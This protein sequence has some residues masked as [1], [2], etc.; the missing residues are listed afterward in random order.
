MRGQ[1]CLAGP[2]FWKP[3]NAQRPDDQSE[4]GRN[5]VVK[6]DAESAAPPKTF[7]RLIG[8]ARRAKFD[9]VKKPKQTKRQQLRRKSSRH[10][11]PKD[12]PKSDHLIPH[13]MARI[14]HLHVDG[15]G[16][17]RPTANGEAAKDKPKPMGIRQE[18]IER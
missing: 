9:G 15:A 1:S 2:K 3:L 14:G 17:T 7:K 8:P 11:Q 16:F 4:P 6:H 5:D 12:K 18:R 10:D 13:H